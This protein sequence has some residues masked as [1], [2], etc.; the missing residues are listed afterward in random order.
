M[1]DAT[2]RAFVDERTAESER[3][4]VPHRR[5]LAERC[6]GRG[7]PLASH[8]DASA[9][10]VAESVAHGVSLAEFPTT[11]EAAR[12]SREAG[13]AILMGAPNVV[14]GRSHTGNVPARELAALGLL[15]VLSSDY[16]P[17]SLLHGALLL[18]DGAEPA[19]LPDAIALVT[20]N[21]A[22]VVGLARSRPARA[23]GCAPIS[24][25]WPV[26]TAATCRR[27][28][29][30]GVP[31]DGSR[32]RRPRLRLRRARGRRRRRTERRPARTACSRACANASTATP[33]CTSPRRV[34]TRPYEPG[35]E[36]H[37]SVDEAEFA[38]RLERGGFVVHWDAHGL[39]YGGADERARTRRERLPRRRQR[40]PRGAPRLRARL[41]DAARR[42]RDGR[43]RTPCPAARRARGAR[44]RRRSARASNGHR[45]STPRSPRARARARQQRLARRRR[46]PPRRL[47]R[48]AAR[49]RGGGRAAR[50]RLP[51]KCPADS[52]AGRSTAPP[53]ESSD[54]SPAESPVEPLDGAHS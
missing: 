38:R 45:R 51:T 53:A 43:A 3:H 34:V 7:V 52:P 12:A 37:E 19:T 29:P 17:S 5:A 31:D 42:A 30:S 22:R 28:V 41:P 25:A 4:A 35:G 20:A 50:C 49:R 10:H 9:A 23:G 40:Q 16:V 2:F 15:D 1:D 26:R 24:C 33:T 8:D 14:R 36:P 32:E 39:R 54:K 18:A 47:A 11:I 6:A 13:L 44:A 27:C 21:P 48:R 46:R